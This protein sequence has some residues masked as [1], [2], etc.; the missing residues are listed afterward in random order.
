[1]K[2]NS[3]EDELVQAILQI[4]KEKK[5]Q[6]MDQLA[7]LTKDETRIS[8]EEIVRVVLKLHDEGRISLESPSPSPVTKFGE[9][10]GTGQA[11]WYWI[12]L[13]ATFAT[14]ASVFMVPENAYPFVI[15]RYI[16]GSLFVLW[17]PGYTFI[18]MLFPVGYSGKPADKN[19]DAIQRVALG[20]GL[21]LALVPMVG[22]V[23]NYTPWGIRLTPVVVSLTTLT[24][25]FATV[26]LIRENQLRKKRQE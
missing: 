22:L 12:T 9:Y 24:F 21:S 13:L 11:L 8:K 6:T 2:D 16:L 3:Q 4:M 26:A 14:A 15:I 18:K 1:M 10:L 5:P 7:D 20:I 19:L 25:V 23:L 17:L